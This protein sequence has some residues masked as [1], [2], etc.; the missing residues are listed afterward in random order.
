MA[1][2]V[3]IERAHLLLPH[4]VECAKRGETITY[5]ALAEKI[6]VHHRAIPH[7]LYYIRD[8]ICHPRGLPLLTA[9]VVHKGD[10]Q[11]GEGWLPGGTRGLPVEEKVRRF[12]KACQEV[13]SY[14][15]WDDLLRELSLLRTCERGGGMDTRKQMIS[16]T[17]EFD[18]LKN[19]VRNIIA[20]SHWLTEGEWKESVLRT[21][22]R[23]YVPSTIGVGRGF[24]VR[25]YRNSKQI[26]VLLYDTAA[27]T[28]HRDGD[29]VMITPDAVRGIV[30]VK[31][32]IDCVSALD[33]PLEALVENAELVRSVRSRDDLFVGLFVYETTMVRDHGMAILERLHGIADETH[34]RVVTHLSL[35]KHLFAR[36]WT[37]NPE[38][39][40]SSSYNRWHI[41]EVQSQAPAY[42]VNNAVAVV[43]RESVGQN[44]TLWFDP[45]GKEPRRIASVPLK[46]GTASVD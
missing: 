16:L 17:K 25:S 3:T 9:I 39:R 8:E 1:S 32:R 4:L 14:G 37:H 13:F 21:I 22:L 31:T 2:D 11:P 5:G 34:Q 29:L 23:R 38:V 43:A 27:P 19:R 26:D 18:A 20:G 44:S 6:D 15:C 7:C 35:G 24:V 30:E 33:P 40:T 36:F 10:Q 45:A 46:N 41:Y 28:L 12:E 42:F